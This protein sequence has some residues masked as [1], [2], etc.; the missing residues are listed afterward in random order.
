MRTPPEKTS[1]V[2]KYSLCIILYNNILKMNQQLL[3]AKAKSKLLI[4]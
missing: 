2:N 1:Y 4:V 3:Q